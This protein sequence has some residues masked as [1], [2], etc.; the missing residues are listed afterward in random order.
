MRPTWLETHQSASLAM[1]GGLNE[2][3]SAALPPL[4]IARL[5]FNDLALKATNQDMFEHTPAVPRV[6]AELPQ[7]WLEGEHLHTP[8]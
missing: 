8:K 1:S 6:S 4:A 3:I 5:K 2:Q 7:I